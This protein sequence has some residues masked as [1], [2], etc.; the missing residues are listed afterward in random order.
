MQRFV[1]R[2]AALTALL[3]AIGAI[4][5]VTTFRVFSVTNDE[6]THVGAGLELLEYHRYNLQS[7]NPPL[8]RVIF[9]AI[10][11]LGGMRF[12]P[13][14]NFTDQIH[15]VFYGHGEYKANLFRARAGTLVFFV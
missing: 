2:P 4:R 3:I 13:K 5:M 15:S 6:P 12:N 7:E 8:A 1:F 11:E 10:P 9:A 14:G